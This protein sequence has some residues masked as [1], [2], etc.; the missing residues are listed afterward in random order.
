VLDLTDLD[1]LLNQPGSWSARPRAS[2]AP[3]RPTVPLLQLGAKFLL[4]GLQV[5]ALLRCACSRAE[6]RLSAGQSPR[7]AHTR[8]RSSS[9]G[10]AAASSGRSRMVPLLVLRSGWRAVKPASRPSCQP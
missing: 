3:V 4:H 8:S 6:G 2:A 1:A 9:S 7:A 5:V 10:I